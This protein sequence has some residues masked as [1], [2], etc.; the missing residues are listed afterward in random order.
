M[1]NSIVVKPLPFASV[2]AS[3]TAAGYDPAN[4]GN[5]YMGVVWKSATGATW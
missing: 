2:S 4:I 3:S 1:S 5:D